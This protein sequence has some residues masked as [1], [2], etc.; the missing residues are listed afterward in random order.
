[1]SANPVTQ[2]GGIYTYDFTNN[3]AKAYGGT[4]AQKQLAT[5]IWGMVAGDGNGDKF[6]NPTDKSAVWGTSVGNVGYL[7]GDF[8]MNSQVNNQDKNDKWLLNTS[9][10]SQVPN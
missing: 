5:G 9:Y 6:V 4:A 1:M 2:T 10:Q 8:N 7:S 3:S